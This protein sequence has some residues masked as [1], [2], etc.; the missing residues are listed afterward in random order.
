MTC[1][2]VLLPQDEAYEFE[3]KHVGSFVDALEHLNALSC[4]LALGNR[5]TA[6]A[7]FTLY[8]NV[9]PKG[10]R[11]GLCINFSQPAKVQVVLDLV[12]VKLK[13]LSAET[14][15]ETVWVVCKVQTNKIRAARSV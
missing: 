3:M 5:T 8:D 12:G 4:E 6:E 9:V 14:V 10:E 15:E 13:V 7:A 1:Y 2:H 11:T